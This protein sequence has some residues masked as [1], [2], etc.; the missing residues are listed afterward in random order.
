[1]MKTGKKK[2]M[3]VIGALFLVTIVVFANFCAGYVSRFRIGKEISDLLQPLLTEENQSM[4]LDVNANVNGEAF[5]LDSDIYMTKEDEINYFVIEQMEVPIYI[6]ENLLF[7]ENGHAFKLAEKAE[8]PEL[9]YKNL[10]LQVAAVYEEFDITCVKTDFQTIYSAKVTGEQVQKLL[11]A[12][13]PMKGIPLEGIETLN[14]EMVAQ[15]EQL[16]EIRMMGN[17]VLNDSEVSV[18]IIL[19]QFRILEAGAYD[20]PEAVAQAVGTVDEAT[21]FNL[22]EDLYRLF[23]AFDK[24]SKE[25]KTDGTVALDINCGLLHIENT[26]PISE[27]KVKDI[28]SIDEKEIENLPAV[29][30]F[31]C[32][33]SEIRSI[34]TTQGHA[35]TLTLDNA[36]M[37]KISEMIVPELVNY[38]IEFTAGNIEILLEQNEISSIAV[39]INGNV[40]ILFT[41]I[42]MEVI[43]YLTI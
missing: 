18:E 22:T 25:A 2:W 6:V 4:H 43:I 33:E 11:E 19:S 12:A 17:V 8:E 37:Q 15:N 27:L 10:F 28:E 31:L 41:E 24:F 34:E 42:P 23:I 16:Y 32:M 40:N 38:V 29:I 13:V 35:Y 9:D 14:L 39:E 21:L 7:F 20:I 30:G 1:M 3:I 26:Y 36:S 5:L